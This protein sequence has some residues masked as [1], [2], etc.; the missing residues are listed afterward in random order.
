MTGQ[1]DFDQPLKAIASGEPPRPRPDEQETANP[2]P[3]KDYGKGDTL[4]KQ[5]QAN[6]SSITPDKQRRLPQTSHRCLGK[7]ATV[8][9]LHNE[10]GHVQAG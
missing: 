9:A 5:D 3:D 8:A 2:L 6:D 4:H 1:N 7:N 10:Q